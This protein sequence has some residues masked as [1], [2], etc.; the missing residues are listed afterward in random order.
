MRTAVAGIVAQSPATVAC[1]AVVD[2]LLRIANIAQPYEANI[3]DS[4]FPSRAA[5][6]EPSM[7]AALALEVRSL[8]RVGSTAE[9][10]CPGHGFKPPPQRRR[11]VRRRSTYS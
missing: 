11:P 6:L 10:E 3:V 4:R 9:G 5:S 1:V 8:H 7:D 2:K